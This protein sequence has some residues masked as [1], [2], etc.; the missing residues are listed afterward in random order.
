VGAI[1]AIVLFIP[2]VLAHNASAA[3]KGLYVT[4]ANRTVRFKLPHKN[5]GTEDLVLGQPDFTSNSDSTA[6]S[7]MSVPTGVIFQPSS[8]TLW[9]ADTDNSRVLGFV[10]G[11]SGFSNGQDADIELGNPLFGN[12]NGPCNVAQNGLCDPSDVAF[13]SAGNLWVSDAGG[14]R[15]LEFEPPFSTGQDASVV[16]GKPDFTSRGC[17]TTQAGL[18]TPES[19]AFDPSGNLWV[20]D[21]GNN[22]IVEYVP[23][24]SNGQ[25]ASIQFGQF[26]FSTRVCSAG[27]G[28]I[29]P[30]GGG[31]VRSD[32]FGNIWEADTTDNRV[33]RFPRGSGFT[34]AENADVVLG[35]PD[36][37]SAS[38]LPPSKSSLKTPWGLTFDSKGNLFVSQR[39][40][41][42][43]SRFAAKKG[44]FKIN[45]NAD[46]VIGQPNFT[47]G[48]C[49]VSQTTLQN[50]RGL[51]FGP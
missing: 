32:K 17:D 10:H 9:V 7:G 22:R 45:Q 27:P 16:I 2:I 48:S 47:T 11:G 1:Y 29:C 34:N 31:Q 43:V 28:G 30:S 40:A 36:F 8:K 35:Q 37:T 38:A 23:P 18:C 4:D 44:K 15:V 19:L 24:F 14:S 41:C 5:G 46:L 39:G 51:S 3:E 42:R 49:A 12:I 33:I 50:P 20:L 13:D 6:L 21:G 26:D 25:N